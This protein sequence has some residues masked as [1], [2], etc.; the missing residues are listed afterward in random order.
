MNSLVPKAEMGRWPL[1]LHV[2][3]G[4]TTL[5]GGA[6]SLCNWNVGSYFTAAGEV[7]RLVLVR[8]AFA[9]QQV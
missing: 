4:S 1:A 3:V 9:G 8:R 6:I 7:I 2:P 5:D